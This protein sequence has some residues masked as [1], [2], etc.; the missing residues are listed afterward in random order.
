MT[1]L[2]DPKRARGGATLGIATALSLTIG[3]EMLIYLALGGVATVLMWVDDRDQR[4]RL[5]AYAVTLAGGSALGF[6]G[7]ASYANRLAVCDALSPVWLSDALLG[8][9]LMLG[10]A[11][12]PPTSMRTRLA[13]AAGSGALIAGFHAAMWPHCLSRLEGVSPELY[14]VWLSHVKEARP[15]Y[16]HGW[17]VAAL[18]VA[19]PITGLFG[20]VWLAWR[21]RL[22]LGP[23][24]R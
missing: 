12:L 23:R 3:L 19:L 24:R 20:W 7:F 14:R 1:G 16:R 18:I 22:E 4:R 2:A 17:Q 6:L 15:V 21:G 13:L 5:A 10:L 9:A 8:G 11:M